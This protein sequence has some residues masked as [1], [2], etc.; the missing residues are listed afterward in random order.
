MRFLR[1]LTILALTFAAAACASETG[2]LGHV[3]TLADLQSQPVLHTDDGWQVQLGW[4]ESG[5]AGGPWIIVYAYAKYVRNAQR[6]GSPEASIANPPLGPVTVR[7]AWNNEV[8][9]ER[10]S[11]AISQTLPGDI[12]MTPKDGP[13]CQAVPLTWPGTCVVQV[14]QASGK[15]L[16]ARK[17]TVADSPACY[18]HDFAQL[19]GE[20][21]MH[22]VVETQTA[23]MY[24]VLDGTAPFVP[25]NPSR[26]LPGYMDEPS[27]TLE[28]RNGNF[29]VTSSVQMVEW[30]DYCLMARWWVN[31]KAVPAVPVPGHDN[32]ARDI[33][34]RISGTRQMTV[35]FGYPAALDA[36]A[37][38]KVALQVMYV[39][40]IE[41]LFAEGP[42]PDAFSLEMGNDYPVVPLL[43]NKIEF[44][45]T[46]DLIKL[47][48]ANQAAASRER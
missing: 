16:A 48:A 40:E 2:S 44:V 25:P 10:A 34:R 1:L 42:P 45:V 46:Q 19:Y 22:T 9:A 24:P 5:P 18:W 7:A 23:A 26:P 15:V 39:P 32:G 11:E 36:K 41:P 33:A 14:R 12:Q 35:N 4:G 47:R 30:P 21:G 37:G 17:F 43:S 6:P 3:R 20:G 28:L 27:F 13:Y 29:I 31:G 8:G 38:D